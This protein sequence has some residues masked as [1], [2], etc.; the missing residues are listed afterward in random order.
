MT[1]ILVNV[2]EDGDSL[3]NAM[4]AALYER[5]GHLLFRVWEYLSGKRCPSRD[6]L[7][8]RDPQTFHAQQKAFML[9]MRGVLA[10]HYLSVVDSPVDR[11]LRFLKK[12]VSYAEAMDMIEMEDP[13]VQIWWSRALDGRINIRQLRQ[14]I[15]DQVR[16]PGTDT[17]NLDFFSVEDLMLPTPARLVQDRIPM[18][19][20]EIAITGD[21]RDRFAYVSVFDHLN[22]SM[23]EALRGYTNL[24]HNRPFNAS[25]LQSGPRRCL[26]GTNVVIPWGDGPKPVTWSFGGAPRCDSRH[27]G[28]PILNDVVGDGDCF[29]RALYQAAAAGGLSKTVMERFILRG[30]NCH[31]AV[32]GLADPEKAFCV[33]ARKA[34]AEY[35]VHDTGFIEA[36]TQEFTVNLQ[37]FVE[38][39]DVDAVRRV[40]VR[41][42]LP[43]WLTKYFVDNKM[44]RHAYDLDEFIA[45]CFSNMQIPGLFVSDHDISQVAKILRPV[46]V[47]ISIFNTPSH[48]DPRT[49]Y[50]RRVNNNHFQWL[51]WSRPPTASVLPSPSTPSVTDHRGLPP[52]FFG[53]PRPEAPNVTRNRRPMSET[54]GRYGT[55]KARPAAR[56]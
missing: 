56:K 33:C 43:D 31:A 51:S 30:R 45:A 4:F 16:A 27:R 22:P 55:G 29:Y 35:S 8:Y 19:S 44:R 9:L 41:E 46:H 50:L 42:S 17:G 13:L 54:P 3:F 14:G 49:L 18:N 38:A 28:A 48:P 11:F 5:S 15:S 34:V 10:D 25:T 24:Y 12:G 36:L 1:W 6:E 20:R 7:A 2:Q 53:N 40:G 47:N 21:N 39:K 52:G 26:P 37:Q 23:V 32:M